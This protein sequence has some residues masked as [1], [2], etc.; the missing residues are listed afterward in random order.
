VDPVVDRDDQWLV[1]TVTAGGDQLSHG[2]GT[3]VR[4]IA[5]INTFRRRSPPS[6]PP[7]L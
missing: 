2:T 5:N 1:W 7:S 6:W 3:L 4:R